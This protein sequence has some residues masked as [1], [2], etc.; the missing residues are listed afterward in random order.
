MSFL[1][2][3]MVLKT[4]VMYM[5]SNKIYRNMQFISF[6]GSRV[7]YPLGPPKN[8]RFGFSYMYKL[9][10]EKRLKCIS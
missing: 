2:S 1:E 5:Y 9:K 3:V 8:H 7:V 10:I 6:E 4:Y